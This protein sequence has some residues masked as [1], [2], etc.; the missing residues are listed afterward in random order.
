M[1]Q[2]SNEITASLRF[3]INLG[4]PV[5]AQQQKDGE[6]TGITIAL[7]RKITAAMNR[8]PYFSTYDAAGNVVKL[9]TFDAWDIAFLA[10][11][12]QPGH[13][14]ISHIGDAGNQPDFGS[15]R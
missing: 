14:A 12:L 5:L 13:E 15:G 6:L 8:T 7:A 3:A 10:I 1:A 9:A 11:P 4:N 2:D